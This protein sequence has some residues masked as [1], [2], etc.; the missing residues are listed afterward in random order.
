MPE[1]LKMA[2]QAKADMATAK[3][4]NKN[5]IPDDMISAE[6]PENVR[7]ILNKL[8]TYEKILKEKE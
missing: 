6:P 8:D 7:E 5:G 4:A 1:I 2:V 3:H